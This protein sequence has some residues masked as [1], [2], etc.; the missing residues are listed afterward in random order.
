MINDLE[1]TS[2]SFRNTFTTSIQGSRHLRRYSHNNTGL[3]LATCLTTKSGICLS[4]YPLLLY[5][6]P[7]KY[8]DFRK[9]LRC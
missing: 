2:L 3:K 7:W 6:K 8:N 9:K 4:N 1:N 5:S